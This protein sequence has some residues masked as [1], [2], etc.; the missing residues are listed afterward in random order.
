MAGDR[1]LW[2]NAVVLKELLAGATG[3][4]MRTIE[5]LERSFVVTKR[6][7]V[8]NLDDWKATGVLLARLARKYGYEQI[9]RGRL[10]NDAL[11]AVSSA[12]CGVSVVT[13]NGSDFVRLAEFCDFRWEMAKV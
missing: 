7:I 5:V 4:Q 12:R 6:L 9:G 1:Q 2:M 3:H 8:P 10:T 13:L 11:I